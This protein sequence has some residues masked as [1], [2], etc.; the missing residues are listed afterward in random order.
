[1]IS[2]EN[3]SEEHIRNLQLQSKKDPI[4]L[5]RT[6]FAF[7]LLEALSQTGLT[8][9]FKGGTSLMLLL[10]KPMRLSTDIDVVVKPG[11]DIDSYIEKAGK[12]FPF[13]SVI[14][15]KRAKRGTIN[16]RHFKFT[17]NSPTKINGNELHILLDVLFEDN[18]YVETVEKEI[19]NEILIT[20]GKNLTVTMPSIDCMLGD[21]LTAFAPHTIGIPMGDK[22]MEIMKQFFDIQTLIDAFSDFDCVKSTY[23]TVS[24]REIFYRGLDISPD[25]ALLDT[26]QASLTIG[27]R[28]KINQD[29][30]SHLCR[31]TKEV[32]SH[33]YSHGFSVEQASKI[34]PKVI[35]MAACLL[36]GAQFI[37]INDA[38][39][40]KTELITQPDL[41]A[42]KG[43]RRTTPEGYAHLICADRL[44]SEYRSK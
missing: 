22:D 37:R 43:L 26:I 42:L 14:E 39:N 28:G 19:K 15:Q 33:I 29:D 41:Q 20:E 34:A 18:P 4:L 25:E 38:E 2:K 13:I 8:F 16:K 23:D 32:S 5:E 27:A 36:T 44:L 1:M 40:Y 11:T 30:F 24:K 21:K 31:G 6:I 35:H 9:V 7:G 3:Y 17:Y 10:P 12:I